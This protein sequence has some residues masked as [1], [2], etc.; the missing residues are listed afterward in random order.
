VEELDLSYYGVHVHFVDA[1][2]TE[3][4]SR[5]RETFPRE[6]AAPSGSAV[7][8]VSYVVTAGTPPGT[9]EHARYA[10]SRDGVEVFSPATEEDVFRWL[11]HDIDLA[12]AERSPQML[13][14]HA[15]VVGWRGL[16]L[17][18]PGPGKT[19]TSTLVAELVRR[20][21]VYYSDTFAV[22][23]EAGRVHRYARPLVLGDERRQPSDLRLEREEAPAE[24]LPIGLIVAGAYQPGCIWRPAIVRGARAL[25]PLFE[26]TVREKARR[27]MQIAGRVA[28]GVVTLQGPW[29]EAT[30]VAGHLL[31]LVDDAFISH[32]SAASR[33]G[34]RSL[35]EDL[36]RVAE[37]RFRSVSPEPAQPISRGPAARRLVAIVTPVHRLPLSADEH[38]SLRHLRRYLGQFDRYLIGPH[39]PPQELSDFAVPPIAAR[40]F[41]DRVGYS[42]L[43][44]AE[45][46]YRAFAAYEYILIYQ[47][48]SLVFSDELEAWCRQGWDYIGAPWFHYWHPLQFT[49]LENP[50]DPVDRFGTVGNGGFSLRSVESA[51]AVLNSPRRR[52]DDHL[53]REFLEDPRSH[54]DIFWSFGAPELVDHFRIPRPRQALEFAFETAPRYCFQEN[55][56]RL[57]FG[58]HGWY[59]WEA[60]F[61]EPFLL[62]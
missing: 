56:G 15:G 10:A 1:A 60:E 2:G 8:P 49:S 33:T 62:K 19:G 20:G 61:W 13:F 44:V 9:E 29:A 25:W 38:I 51:L 42:R 30:E 17:V 59:K 11:W 21:A 55:A 45:Q 7:I 26:H 54:E 22:L 27:L 52:L 16:A 48:D 41:A 3:L 43:L 14:V 47:L 34:A 58:C 23:D 39:L 35:S 5:L 4:C 24:P 57:P 46:F 31:D 40:Y 53:L 32:A 6:D 18:I 28:P 37:M 12:L 36:A 50:A